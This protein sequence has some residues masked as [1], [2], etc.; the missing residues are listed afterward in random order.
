MKNDVIVL[1]KGGLGNQLFQYAFARN[2]QLKYGYNNI[3]LD[4]SELDGIKDRE[5]EL[6]KFV[7]PDEC[8]KV[9][10]GN[11]YAAYSR[12]RNLLLKFGMRFLPKSVYN[13]EAKGNKFIWD[14][15]E[16]V[17]VD[18]KINKSADVVINGYW[19][20]EKYFIDNVDTIFNDLKIEDTGRFE[21]SDIYK[22]ISG[23][24][25]TCI[26]V[27][28]T[29]YLNI[30]EYN[31]FG[32]EYYKQ[33]IEYVKER[34]DSTFFVFSDDVEAAQKML[35]PLAEKMQFVKYKGQDTLSDFFLMSQCNNFIMANSS[36]SWWAQYLGKKKD[37]V[38]APKKWNKS[39]EC[40][41]IYMD[42][43]ILI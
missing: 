13:L 43:W 27:R 8:V 12:R 30:S 15:S 40:E 42:E 38:V 16:Y 5:Y 2:I 25:S 23:T 21:K 22:A 33:G 9:Y 28:L 1:M 41:D 32:I 11:E 34:T 4:V 35:S 19:Q 39:N 7:L 20:S 37:I 17:N 10:K 6:D 26:H 18:D 29:D 36:Y 31:T 24:N 14:N 3:I